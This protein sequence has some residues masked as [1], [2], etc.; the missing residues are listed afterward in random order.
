MQSFDMIVSYDCGR[1]FPVIFEH[2]LICTLACLI[3]C[4]LAY[5]LSVLSVSLSVCLSVLL[6]PPT[7][8]SPTLGL[9]PRSCDSLVCRL[10]EDVCVSSSPRIGR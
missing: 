8:F 5:F 3:A 1:M 9:S 7:F 2:V 6:F 4:I 10:L